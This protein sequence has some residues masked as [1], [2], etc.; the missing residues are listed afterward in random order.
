MPR[1]R[2]DRG[3]PSARS[4]P[5]NAA[6]VNRDLRI[7]DASE[8]LLRDWE[9]HAADAARQGTHPFHAPGYPELVGRI[10]NHAKEAGKRMPAAL[11]Q[12]LDDHRPLVRSE[13][14]ATK[15]ADRLDACMKKRD[16]LLERAGDRLSYG[17][18]VT[19]LGRPHRRWRREA[20]A[21]LKA[22]RELIGNERHAVHLDALGGRAT[23]R[24]CRRPHRACRPSRPPSG[25][26]GYAAW[27]TLEDRV[28]E[29]GR[30]RFFLPEHESACRS[31]SVAPN[32]IRDDAARSFVLDEIQLRD[33]MTK[34]EKRLQDVAQGLR[35]RRAEREVLQ[36]GGGP[37]V[38]QEGYGRWEVRTR[39]AVLRAG[40]ILE[41]KENFSPHFAD[42]PGLKAELDTLSSELNRMLR[43]ERKEWERVLSES[44]KEKMRQEEQQ[45]KSQGRGFSM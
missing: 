11:A 22:G 25:M 45:G 32:L 15:L 43:D 6:A 36:A 12:V 21:A 28:R 20:G 27:E 7:P 16:E 26:G 34:R 19:E 29:T 10:E 40:E 42:K 13:R 37:V 39:D 14:E 33:R 30:H 35:D 41:G 9:A 8:A 18:P 24:A 31:M 38:E 4:S 2:A 23:G 44:I 1:P 3:R 17:Q 5:G